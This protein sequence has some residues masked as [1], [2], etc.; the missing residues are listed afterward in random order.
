MHDRNLSPHFRNHQA[1]WT[2]EENEILVRMWKNNHYVHEICTALDKT[3]A[4][5]R[6]YVQRNRD[7][8]GLEKRP[9]NFRKINDK[10]KLHGAAYMKAFNKEWHGPVPFKHWTITQRWSQS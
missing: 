9:A 8:L 4:C 1:L 2:D 3:E 6:N 10:Y 7:W 5:I